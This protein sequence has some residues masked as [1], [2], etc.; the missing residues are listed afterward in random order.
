MQNIFII[1]SL[2]FFLKQAQNSKKLWIKF[3]Y[4]KFLNKILKI[5]FKTKLISGFFI[6]KSILIIF[7]KYINLKPIINNYI[8]FSKPSKKML[9]LKKKILTLLKKNPQSFFFFININNI[10][11]LQ[12]NKIVTSI[13]FFKIN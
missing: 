5:L 1:D 12:L 3:K 11:T 9:F 4:T 7:L 13:L 10:Q 8:I 2:L 6:K